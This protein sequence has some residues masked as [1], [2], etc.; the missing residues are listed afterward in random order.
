MDKYDL[1][2]AVGDLDEKVLERSEKRKS[3]PWK[4]IVASVI[5]VCAILVA[6]AFIV[7]EIRYNNA[8]ENIEQGKYKEAYITLKD[9]GDFKDCKTLL[10]DFRVEYRRKETKYFD[11]NGNLSSTS[12][13]ERNAYGNVML[14]ASY[15]KDGNISTKSETEFTYDSNGD[16]ILAI[17]R[18]KNQS[19]ISRWEYKYDQNRN[20]TLTK[21]FD[22]DGALLEKTAW[23]YDE[24]GNKLLEEQFDKTDVVY[25]RQVWEYDGENDLV[26]FTE[27]RRNNGEFLKQSFRKYNKD[28][29]ITLEQY[30]SKGEPRSST[31]WEYDENGNETLQEGRDSDGNVYYKRV[32][33]YNEKGNLTYYVRF[34]ENLKTT[35]EWFDEDG[36]ALYSIYYK[37]GV[38]DHKNEYVCDSDGNIILSTFYDK[39]GN[40]RTYEER[41]YNRDGQITSQISYTNNGN[42]LGSVLIEYN[43][44]GDKI[45]ELLLR[46]GNEIK[47]IECEYDDDGFVT[48]YYAPHHDTAYHEVTFSDP[49]VLYEPKNK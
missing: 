40:M 16:L 32:H 13:T 36:N 46:D 7:P 22:K 12:L 39:D 5:C 24:N 8:L 25:S 34:D 31:V 29:N 1:Y 42:E 17:S 30:Y 23:K 33:K 20:L 28:G 15:D 38:L 21:R 11:S 10:E 41:E 6:L 49:I 47:R 4:A 19:I 26:S 27:Y 43:E 3:F 18:D 45:L 48:R 37:N 9:L 14:N 2:N 35:E 44:F